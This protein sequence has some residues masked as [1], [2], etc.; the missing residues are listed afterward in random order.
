MQGEN[1]LVQYNGDYI[2][3]GTTTENIVQITEQS[4]YNIIIKDLYIDV[5]GSDYSAF[6]ANVYK[7]VNNV[8]KHYE[9]G[10]NVNLLLEGNN[11]LRGGKGP[12]LAWVGAKPN[13]NGE[14]NGSTLTIDGN[15]KLE[16]YGGD[17]K[18]TSAIGSSY[19]NSESG[20]EVNNI[21]I[22][23]GK[24]KAVGSTN[25]AGIGAVLH[26][27][28]NNIVINNGNIEA[29]GK[30]MA[31]GIGASGS[32]IADNII[33]NGGNIYSEGG[34]YGSGIGGGNLK[35]EG[36]ILKITGG[37]IYAIGSTHKNFKFEAIGSGIENIIIE[38]GN[39]KQIQRQT[40]VYLKMIQTM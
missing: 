24:I 33:I 8:W 16:A 12:G 10:V 11:Y 14:K 3:T 6:N 38:G 20:G 40:Q 39:I 4:T 32:G 35:N 15:G 2:I 17:M 18:W 22:N 7:A 25:G 21:T 28:S 31:A 23:G 36:S 37:N 5:S 30:N 34:I 29:T 27:K 9:T 26:G 1:Q 19:S 13:V